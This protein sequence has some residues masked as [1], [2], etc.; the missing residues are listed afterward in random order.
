MRDKKRHA[1]TVQRIGAKRRGIDWQFTYE[2]W[3]AWWGDDFDKRGIRKGEL[4][5]ARYNDVGAYHPNNVR[6]ATHEE[7]VIEAMKGK[8]FSEETKVKMSASRKRYYAT[9]SSLN[10]N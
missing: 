1:Y 8:K 5:M 10:T 7:N 3:L 2:E 9:Q 4:C 6:K